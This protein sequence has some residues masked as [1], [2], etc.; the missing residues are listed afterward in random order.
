M[1]PIAF[2][3]TSDGVDQ[4]LEIGRRLGAALRPRDVLGLVGRL[5]AGKTHLVKGIAGGLGIHDARDVNS[6]TFVLVNE[7]AARFRIH[8]LDAYRLRGADELLDLGFE[9]FCADDAVTI[10]EWADRVEPAMPT[11]ALWISIETTGE[12]TRALAF[13][14]AAWEKWARLTALF[15]GKK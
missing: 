15:Q 4:T 12:T 14:S 8:H 1:T 9:E 13:H 11:D 10:V 3:L 5:G 6:P 7:Y 2:N